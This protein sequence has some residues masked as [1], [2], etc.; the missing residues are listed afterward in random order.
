[1]KTSPFDIDVVKRPSPMQNSHPTKQNPNAQDSTIKGVLLNKHIKKL[2]NVSIERADNF[3]RISSQLLILENPDTIEFKT[4]DQKEEG[5]NYKKALKPL[6]IALGLGLAGVVGIN[7]MANK[8]SQSIANDVRMYRPDDLAKNINLLEEDHFALFRFM[9]DPSAPNLLG[10]AGVVLMTALTAIAKNFTDGLQEI[11]TKKQ[12]YDIDYDMQENLIQVETEAFSGK[13]KVVNTLLADSTK[14]FK[15]VLGDKPKEKTTFKNFLSFKGENKA[16]NKETPDEKKEKR[17]KIITLM[18]IIAGVGG[19]IALSY[20]MFKKYKGTAANL[21]YFKI[22]YSDAQIRAS[23]DEAAKISDKDK[24]VKAM[25]DIFKN[26]NATDERISENLGKIN[27][28]TT[29][30][31]KK[32]TQE[33]RDAQP[34]VKAPEALGGYGDKIQYYCYENEP[35]GHLYNWILEPENKFNKYFF[36]A[37]SALTSISYVASQCL[38]A[39]K[40]VAVKKENTRSEL[41]LKKRLVQTEVENFKSKKLSAIN[42]LMENFKY[43]AEKGK[44]KE[45]L[46]ELAENILNEIKNGPPYIYS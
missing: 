11:W 44:S 14:Y 12:E 39:I 3:D 33:V 41:N 29:E 25:S 16:K 17:K 6:I 32:I 34:Y 45:E 1:M 26:I 2:D 36:I 35:R 10:L 5:F 22:R 20:S 43:Q 42:P 18:S 8:Y 46:K 13:L 27:G 30:E 28:I 40:K 21:N 31:I 9:R 15:S 38:E 23:L 24:A 7:V 4:K 37:L 19:F